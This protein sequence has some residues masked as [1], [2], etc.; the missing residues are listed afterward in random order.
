MKKEV[1]VGGWEDRFRSDAEIIPVRVRIGYALDPLWSDS[2]PYC[3]YLGTNGKPF[4]ATNQ[5][6]FHNQA[7]DAYEAQLDQQIEVNNGV[8][9]CVTAYETD[10]R[11]TASMQR[12]FRRQ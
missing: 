10:G 6:D 8:T 1:M 3:Y 7:L 9:L 5:M 2:D 11:R 4:T 12:S